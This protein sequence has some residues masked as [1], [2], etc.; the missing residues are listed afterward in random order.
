VT[1]TQAANTENRLTP[2]ARSD[3]GRV[4]AAVFGELPVRAGSILI[5]ISGPV[6][7]FARLLS[8]LRVLVVGLSVGRRGQAPP[9]PAAGRWGSARPAGCGRPADFVRTGQGEERDGHGNGNRVAV[10]RGEF[11]VSGGIVLNTPDGVT[12]PAP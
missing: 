1:A 4:V 5:F 2:V 3:R 9:R 11:Y 12:A 10:E 6:E 8:G 7:R